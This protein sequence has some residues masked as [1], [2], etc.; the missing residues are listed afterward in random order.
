MNQ[1]RL[2]AT[3]NQ[4]SAVRYTPVGIPVLELGLHHQSEVI[5]AN[6]A[7]QLQF[8]ME[9]IALGEVALQL[10]DLPLGSELALQGFMAP[11][12][13]DS[14]FL[15]FHIQQAQA[16]YAGGATVVV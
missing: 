5:E 9:A 2:Q 3:L 12:R 4:L 10:A 6:L 15:V 11:R 14:S 16:Y 1:F 7:R 13:K 8:A